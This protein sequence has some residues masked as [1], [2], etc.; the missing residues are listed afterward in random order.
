MVRVCCP[1]LN[2]RTYSIFNSRNKVYDIFSRKT[3]FTA[4]DVFYLASGSVS[5]TSKHFWKK[6]ILWKKKIY[7]VAWT[8]C[9]MYVTKTLTQSSSD[10]WPA[11]IPNC[12]PLS[13]ASAPTMLDLCQG[14]RVGP[15]SIILTTGHYPFDFKL[16]VF[17][18]HLIWIHFLLPTHK[19]SMSPFCRYTGQSGHALR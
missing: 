4:D 6:K 15:C 19:Q 5:Q 18:Q 16:F 8:I 14:L 13:H 11:E 9:A 1:I 7:H 17:N 2:E 3:E 10:G 12:R